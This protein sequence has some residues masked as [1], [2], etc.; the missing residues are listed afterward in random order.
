MTAYYSVPETP[1]M[2]NVESGIVVDREGAKMA[3]DP[4]EWKHLCSARFGKGRPCHFN[5]KVCWTG[6]SYRYDIFEIL[7]DVTRQRYVALRW[8]NGAGEGWFVFRDRNDEHQKILLDLIVTIPS[9][10]DRWDYCHFLWGSL[11][12]VALAAAVRSSREVK[13]AFVEGRL[14]KRK[15]RGRQEYKVEIEPRVIQVET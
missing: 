10:E 5:P 7:D 6:D 3:I 14:K 12:C 15:I 4:R 9:E 8:Q 13:E 1:N 2:K 11:D